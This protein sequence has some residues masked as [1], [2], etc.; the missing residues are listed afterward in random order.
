[1]RVRTTPAMAPPNKIDCV[2]L[3]IAKW[4][5]IKKCVYTRLK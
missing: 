1:M 2:L 4:W 5:M 3:G